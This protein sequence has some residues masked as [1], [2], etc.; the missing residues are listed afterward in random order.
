MKIV[1]QQDDNNMMTIENKRTQEIVT[2]QNNEDCVLAQELNNHPVLTYAYRDW[3]FN[4][5]DWLVNY[6]FAEPSLIHLILTIK[7]YKY[8]QLSSL[9]LNIYKKVEK[10][11]EKLE[12]Q[13]VMFQ[14]KK[15]YLLK[16]EKDGD[17]SIQIPLEGEYSLKKYVTLFKIYELI[18]WFAR[19]RK[20]ETI[21]KICVI[22]KQKLVEKI[23]PL[24]DLSI[25]KVIGAKVISCKSDLFEDAV[26]N[27][28]VSIINFLPRID[29]SRVMFSIFVSTANKSAYF[30]NARH[31]KHVYNTVQLSVLEDKMSQADDDIDSEF[32]ISSVV[33]KNEGITPE[34]FEDTILDRIDRE[35][36]ADSLDELSALYE[37]TDM[38]IDEVLKQNL[39][40]HIN[41]VLEFE[42]RGN[43]IV[44]KILAY[45][46]TI[47]S[48]KV[49]KL[50]YSKI[51]AEFFIDLI[52]QSIPE[53]VISKYAELFLNV[54]NFDELSNLQEIDP[55]INE[56]IVKMLK[57]W[58]KAKQEAKLKENVNKTN[59]MDK[60]VEREQKIYE[61][62]RDNKNALEELLKFRKDC[63]T[64]KLDLD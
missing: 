37:A 60:K 55:I 51:Y 29:P 10:I 11:R 56:S 31:L 33:N 15:A 57:S 17:K 38:E 2:E 41:T 46:F 49:R 22:E 35:R 4:E 5:D 13:D 20:E 30:F 6:I 19:L 40:E 42:N 3:P 54:I 53:K 28:W 9:V 62:I 43:Y 23:I 39:G 26:S 59:K 16:A 12:E 61:F 27:A 64:F 48:G 45:S 25:R 24:A 58:I 18:G 52:K 34:S 63:L 14:K 47:L 32:F 50:C 36:N 1:M 21:F 8:S 44:N 7:N